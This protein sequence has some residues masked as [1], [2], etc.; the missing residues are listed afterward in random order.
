ML[1]LLDHLMIHTSSEGT[2]LILEMELVEALE[3]DRP[4]PSVAE[5]MEEERVATGNSGR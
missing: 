3:P 5:R 2:I 4:A 1:R